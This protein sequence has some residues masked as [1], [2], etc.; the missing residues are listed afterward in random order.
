MKINQALNHF[1]WKL[2]NKWSPTEKDLEAYNSLID[3]VEFQNGVNLEQNE[4][5]AKL[6]IEKVILLNRTKSYS[7]SQAIGAIDEILSKSVYDWCIM[8]QQEMPMMRFNSVGNHKYPLKEEDAYN[9]TKIRDR[10][11]KIIE[12]FEDELTSALRFTISE[13]DII[14]FV[15]KHITRIIQK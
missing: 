11:A 7:G 9:L 8:L 4:A 5:L 3:Y 10:N 6:W 2:E 12:E 15:K 1:K 13:D 14:K